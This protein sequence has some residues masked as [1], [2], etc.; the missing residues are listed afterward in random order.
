MILV[1][2]E[3]LLVLYIIG[4]NILAAKF[5]ETTLPKNL[6]AEISLKA[7]PCTWQEKKLLKY[8][9]SSNIS[10]CDTVNAWWHETKWALYYR[11]I[12]FKE[13][14]IVFN[15]EETLYV[16]G[17]V[18]FTWILN[19]KTLFFLTVQEDLPFVEKE[20]KS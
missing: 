20:E 17:L 13:L 4:V 7:E 14:D 2:K 1:S 8:C 9:T 15:P 11:L 10:V 5:H 6:V 16:G 3:E 19:F 18:Y 12:S